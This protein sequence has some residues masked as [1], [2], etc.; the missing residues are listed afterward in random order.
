MLL[1]GRGGAFGHPQTRRVDR[2]GLQ[3]LRKAETALHQPWI[4]KPNGPQ[5]KHS[6]VVVFVGVRCQQLNKKPRGDAK[7]SHET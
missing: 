2:H 1:C 4:P 5:W 7:A 6:N 3:Q